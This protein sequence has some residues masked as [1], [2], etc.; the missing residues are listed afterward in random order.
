MFF[1][2]NASLIKEGSRKKTRVLLGD[3]AVT[4]TPSAAPNREPSSPASVLLVSMGMDAYA[5]VRRSEL[6]N[7]RTFPL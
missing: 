1:S 4:P 3:T 2:E 7:K 6:T 5:T